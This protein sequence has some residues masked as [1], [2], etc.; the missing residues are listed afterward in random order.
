VRT[1]L[2]DPRSGAVTIVEVEGLDPVRLYEWLWSRYRII[3]SPT[4]F[5]GLSGIR[6]TPNVFTT[7]AEVDTFTEAMRIAL[8][9]GV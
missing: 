3:T 6:V 8:R 1:P 4:T 5:A 7:F 2:D 9:K